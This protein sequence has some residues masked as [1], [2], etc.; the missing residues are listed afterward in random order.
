MGREGSYEV[1]RGELGLRE[2]EDIAGVGRIGQDKVQMA[3]GSDMITV[4]SLHVYQM[5]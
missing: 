5:K 3:V 2:G 4:T 1:S